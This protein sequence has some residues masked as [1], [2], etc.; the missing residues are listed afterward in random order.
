MTKIKLTDWE[1][2]SLSN[3]VNME[4]DNVGDGEE[5]FEKSL[6][7]LYRTLETNPLDFSD[8]A[9]SMAS[10]LSEEEANHFSDTH[11]DISVKWQK[12]HDKLYPILLKRMKI[13]NKRRKN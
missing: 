12:L 5:E 10:Q 8:D 3:T 13:E 2:S 9:L 7:A 4:L 11:E 6:H 1:I